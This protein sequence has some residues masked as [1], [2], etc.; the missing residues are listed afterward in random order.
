MTPATNPEIERLVERLVA[1]LQRVVDD[2]IAACADRRA[3]NLELL[4]ST[5]ELVAAHAALAANWAVLERLTSEFE[6]TLTELR[7]GHDRRPQ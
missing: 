1:P 6:A 2:F 4:T 5:R 7:P 3:A